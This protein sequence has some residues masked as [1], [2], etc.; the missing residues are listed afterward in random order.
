MLPIQFDLSSLTGVT[1]VGPATLELFVVG[2]D[3]GF[4]ATR[5]NANTSTFNNFGAAPDVQFGTDVGSALD[6]QPVPYPSPGNRFVSWTI[7]QSIV[8]DWI[9]NP[10]S[11]HGVLVFNQE[12]ANSG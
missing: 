5:W 3:F 12:V 11:N 6:V 7:P 10:A 4:Q 1:V 8:Q 2:T 9:D